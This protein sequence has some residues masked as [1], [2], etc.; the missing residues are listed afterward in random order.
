MS[1]EK[2]TTT[3]TTKATTPTPAEPTTEQ[4]KQE[5]EKVL[6]DA[7]SA[8]AGLALSV[9]DKG[10]V[11]E[12]PSAGAV[13]IAF[14]PS[15]ATAEE[16]RRLEVVLS[17][18]DKEEKRSEVLRLLKNKAQNEASLKRLSDHLKGEIKNDTNKI[19][20][21]RELVE[22]G[23]EYRAVRCLRFSDFSARRLTVFR[24][25]SDKVVEDRGL[26]QEEIPALKQPELTF[27]VGS[28]P[29]TPPGTIAEAAERVVKSMERLKTAQANQPQETPEAER[30]AS[31]IETT[32]F[33]VERD[34]DITLKESQ[35]HPSAASALRLVSL[36]KEARALR[37][38]LQE[39]IQ[40]ENAEG[41]ERKAAKE[42]AKEAEK[43]TLPAETPKAEK[44]PQAQ[45]K[46]LA[47]VPPPSMVAPASDGVV[48]WRIAGGSSSPELRFYLNGVESADIAFRKRSAQ[49]LVSLLVEK[50]G[51]AQKLIDRLLEPD[52]RSFSKRT[53]QR[54]ASGEVVVSDGFLSA[55]AF[56]YDGDKEFKKLSAKESELAK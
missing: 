45:Q 44:A 30:S 41:K 28:V 13:S 8:A 23:K 1:D 7:S 25:D 24:L 19:T 29:T 42:A 46:K 54:Y 49:K 9:I 14:P 43:A 3:E 17:E 50:E 10:N 53:V 39:A 33:A 37:A 51:S 48:G 2:K 18:R 55:I 12:E 4:L 35:T 21:L 56:A 32:L 36:D 52:K 31:E 15:F 20:E 27:N 47:I 11:K 16:E 6:K 40:R 34:L 26:K 38:D 5:A 22:A